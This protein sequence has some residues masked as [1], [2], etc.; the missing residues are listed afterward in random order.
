[1]F[2][3]VL[4]RVGVWQAEP[5][6]QLGD[7]QL[8]WQLQ[9][10]E[11]VAPGLGRDPVADVLVEAGLGRRVEQGVGVGLAE[12]GDLQLRQPEQVRGP[13]TGG[14]VNSISDSTPAA[15]STRMPVAAL[16]R[17]SSSADLPTPGAPCT[18]S[19]RLSP[20]RTAATS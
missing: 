15:R 11:R 12:P 10:G 14:E 17:Y 4:P 19:T 5:A 2:D 3:P 13:V 7:G 1:V 8:A 9:Q 20:V 16:S 6:C 18:T